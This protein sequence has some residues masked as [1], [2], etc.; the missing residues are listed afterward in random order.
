MSFN[1]IFT[2]ATKARRKKN[3]LPVIEERM[4]CQSSVG[5]A[6]DSVCHWLISSVIGEL[7]H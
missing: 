4:A 3:S 1:L 6:G 5:L 7:V 2:A